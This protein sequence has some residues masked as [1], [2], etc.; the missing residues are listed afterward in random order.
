MKLDF[1]K[2]KDGDKKFLLHLRKSTMTEHLE[3]AGLFLSDEDHMKRVL[4]NFEN[5]YIITSENQALGLLKYVENENEIAILQLQILPEYQ[6][7]GIGKQVIEFLTRKGENVAKNLS[8]KVLKPNP[9]KRLYERNDFKV[10]GEDDYEFYML[11][12]CIK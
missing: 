2:A 11:K 1:V 10:T 5:S 12:K 8:L 6:G 9:A 7:K 4:F 3:K